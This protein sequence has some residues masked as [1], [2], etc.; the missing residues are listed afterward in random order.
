MRKI[1]SAII[2][3]TINTPTPT[4]AWNIPSITSQLESDNIRTDNTNN[5]IA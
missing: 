5:G 1:T 4:P 3:M 2:A